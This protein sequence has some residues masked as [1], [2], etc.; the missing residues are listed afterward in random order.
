[1]RRSSAPSALRN[2]NPAPILPSSRPKNVPKIPTSVDEL[3]GGSIGGCDTNKRS[4]SRILSLLG[5]N[6]APGNGNSSSA[7]V[8]QIDFKDTGAAADEKRIFEAVYRKMQTKKHK[9]WEGDGTV[10]VS[11]RS[12]VLK[13]E[14]GKE[15]GRISKVKDDV[16]LEEGTQLVIGGK[17]VEFLGL[18]SRVASA[19]QEKR[20]PDASFAQNQPAR[21][22][23]QLNREDDK[24]EEWYLEMP[25][26]NHSHQSAF[27][28]HGLPINTVTVDGFLARH[29]RPHQRDG[30]TFMFQCLMGMTGDEP[31]KFHGLLL[32]DE[33]GL[34][35]TIQCIAL[36]WT[37]MK[38]NVYGRDP[39]I[40]RVLIVTPSSLV[41]N[42]DREIIHWLK[43]H[44]LRVFVVG[45]QKLKDYG[46]TRQ[47]PVVICSY[48]ALVRNIERVSQLRWDLMIC[49][50]AHKIKNPNTKTSQ[51]LR[52][53]PCK[54]KILLTGS[55][56]QNNM[57]EY[58][59]LLD[60]AN[61]GVLGTRKEFSAQ[62]ASPIERSNLADS[63]EDEKELGKERKE[64][65]LKLTAPFVLGRPAEINLKYLP[66]KQDLIVFCAPSPLQEELYKSALGFFWGDD[67]VW[68]EMDI[69]TV[70][71][72]A[73]GAIT[74]LRQV[75]SHPS[76]LKVRP[77]DAEN[78]LGRLRQFLQQELREGEATCDFIE[79]SGKLTVVAGIL[80]FLHE[81]NRE[82]MLRNQRGQTDRVLIVSYFVETLNVLQKMCELQHFSF[83]RIDGQ[84]PS[85]DR[86]KIVTD[87]NNPNSSTFVM[88]LSAKAGG[89]GLNLD[90]ASRVILFDL[91]WNP[92]SDAQSLA[93]V[94]RG[95]QKRPV[96]TYRLLTS[97]SIEEKIFQRQIQKTGNDLSKNS[98]SGLKFTKQELKDLFS[99]NPEMSGTNL[100]HSILNCDCACDGKNVASNQKNLLAGDQEDKLECRFPHINELALWKHITSDN[101]EQQLLD[102]LNV[103][104]ASG[105][106][107]FIFGS[108]LLFQG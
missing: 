19:V 23:F 41:K 28:P 1:M 2:K 30:V 9:T 108:E 98:K 14:N 3:D 91:D 76:L 39:A 58:F 7:K 35:K 57:M 83:S 21:K 56:C 48:E 66:P 38:Q 54:H 51:E 10:E 73:L 25:K 17:E 6:E 44:R 20:K 34:G 81:A 53:V 71:R 11:G 96:I 22:R 42:W 75:C 105:V 27:N 69:A 107:S 47:D 82:K 36:I 101:F 103:T 99:Y 90:G 74:S 77:D 50:E 85:R 94:W 104:F 43:I 29:L 86:M 60:F 67:D 15:M 79:M 92:A 78:D 26:P 40:R 89:T 4:A 32:A 31:G 95:R 70:N 5:A 93:R 68:R 62:F 16:V 18:L 13:D 72:N 55:P 65:L 102:D 106:I 24:N 88:L 12:V 45:D 8:D 61:P 87:F 80:G 63:S 52:R 59:E 97:G 49:D 33:M 100:T 46:T 84:V 37:L 64:E